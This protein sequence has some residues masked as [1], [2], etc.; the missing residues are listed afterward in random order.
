MHPSS[1]RAFERDQ[2]LDLKH[3]GLVDLISRNKTKQTSYLPS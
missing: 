3:P 2:K 1:S